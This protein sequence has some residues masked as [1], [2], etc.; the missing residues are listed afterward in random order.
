MSKVFF[1]ITQYIYYYHHYPYYSYLL[2]TL[3]VSTSTLFTKKELGHIIFETDSKA[4]RI[5]DEVLLWLIFLSVV[6]VMLRSVA[7]IEQMYW[8]RLSLLSW[9]LTMLF[10]VE[11]FLRIRT[12]SSKKWYVFSFYGLVDFISVIP[13]LFLWLTTWSNLLM[14]RSLRLLRLFRVFK[15]GRYTSASG[16]LWNS[17]KR[18]SAKI[19]VFMLSVFI[20][21]LIVGT[22]MYV[23]EWPTAWFVDIPTSIY[24]AIVTITTVWYGDITPV[25]PLWQLLSALL[26]VVWYGILAVPTGIIS[27]EIVSQK[28][29]NLKE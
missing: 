1:L 8:V 23:I 6:V 12:A 21:V 19:S 13:V 15:L 3:Y 7:S 28:H 24:R 2:V 22:L 10:T 5:F 9:I 20:I 14:I 27:A 26:M 18:S 29:E 17:L 16:F 25:T 4:G 11:Y